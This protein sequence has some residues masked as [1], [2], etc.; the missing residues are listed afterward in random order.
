MMD[1][2]FSRR[3]SI[4]TGL[5]ISVGALLLARIGSFQFQLDTAQYLQNAASNAYHTARELVPDRGR[6]YDRNGELLAG[7]EMYYDIGISPNLID[8]KTETA[9]RIGRILGIDPATLEKTLR[10]SK[11]P[12]IRLTDK[13]ASTEIAQQIAKEDI[14]GVRLDPVPRRTYPQ[15]KL[16]GP[17]IG[18]YGADGRGYVGVEEHWNQYLAGQVRFTDESPIPFEVSASN[19]PQ[20][21][22][23]IYLTID[24]SLQELAE[25][26]LEES[27][28]ELNLKRG[29][30]I[31]MDPRNGEI[32]AMASFPT[33]DPNNY[34][35]ADPETLKNPA[36][37]DLYEPGSV[38]KIASMASALDSGKVDRNWTYKDV[39]R[40]VVGGAAI[41]NWDRAAHGSQSFDDVLIRSWNLGTTSAAM[42]M[43]V[44]PFYDYMRDRWGVNT[45]MG[46]D[47]GGEATG[48]L[49]QPGDMYWTDSFLATNSYGQGLQV[50]PLQ[51]LCYTNVI[52]HDGQLMQPHVVMKRVRGDQV[53][54]SEP[55]VMR[56]PIKKETAN[57]IRDI[58]VNV[59][60]KGEADKALV[61]GYKIAGK[62][63]TAQ[64]YNP[65]I[66]DYDPV[67]QMNT[68]VGF[69]PADEP[70]VSILIKFD[71]SPD[72]ASQTAAPVF[73]KL[74]QRLVVLMNI[75]TDKQRAALQAA[76]GNTWEIAGAITR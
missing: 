54:W 48:V 74:V 44:N 66:A 26:T 28:K 45:R 38:F 33:F 35:Q 18:F 64:V 60:Q 14:V 27:L 22:D 15:G 2:T 30:I 23:D 52:A 3:L 61:P 25:Q 62:T 36:V 67:Y 65:A 41:Y 72:F 31:I 29:S 59:V 76:G 63:G 69:L 43:G 40:M 7:N 24:R 42:E 4:L 53:I 56:T 51:M 46:I 11:L 9:N 20:P 10:E 71:D 58:M 19:R 55:F 5:L 75:P 6:I 37:S 57:Q 13:P 8:K 39:G 34:G 17:I 47:L 68:F 1:S 70:R 21:G 73:S 16:A 32:L 12:Y 50:T 49:R